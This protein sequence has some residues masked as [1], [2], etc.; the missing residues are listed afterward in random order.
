[1]FRVPFD[2]AGLLANFLCALG[3]ARSRVGADNVS[4]DRKTRRKVASVQDSSPSSALNLPGLD[5]GAAAPAGASG[6]GETVRRARPKAERNG[7]Y[8]ATF[9]SDVTITLS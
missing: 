3:A 7:A 2:M 4:L 1:M 9:G 8:F 5:T 6:A